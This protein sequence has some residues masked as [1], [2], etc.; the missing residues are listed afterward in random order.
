MSPSDLTLNDIERLKVK[1][2]KFRSLSL[3]MNLVRPYV[4]VKH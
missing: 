4:I 2:T 3:K 1:V